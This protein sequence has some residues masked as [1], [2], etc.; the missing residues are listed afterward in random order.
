MHFEWTKTEGVPVG[1][2]VEVNHLT[3]HD[4]MDYAVE[5]KMTDLILLQGLRAN[6]IHYI[7]TEVKGEMWGTTTFQ[8]RWVD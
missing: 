4:M 2:P 8:P 7:D 1:D 6:A 3:L 5:C